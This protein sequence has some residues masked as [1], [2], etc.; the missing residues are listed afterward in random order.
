MKKNIVQDVIPP[1]KSI[2]NVTLP[3]RTAGLELQP[4]QDLTYKNTKLP[5]IKKET[6]KEDDFVR[7]VVIDD[8]PSKITET[9][10]YQY[11]YDQPKKSGK[12]ILYFSV[13]VFFLAAAFGLSAFF[14]SAEIRVSP[15]QETKTADEIFTAKK[16]VS[17][18]D[19]SYQ[20]VT[21]S[22]DVEK[23]VEA[24][25][26]EEVSKKAQGKIIIYNNYSS[27]SQKLV[28]TTRFETPEGMVFRLPNAVTVPGRALKDGKMVAGSIEVVVEA[29]KVGP[30]YNV[31]LKDFTIP[32]F[33]GDPR[34]NS[35]YA[36]SKTEMTGG[37]VGVQ[38][39]VSKELVQATDKDLE[40]SLKNSL[41]KDIIA[42]IPANYIL[43][44]N[45]ISY[46]LEPTI[47]EDSATENS[48]FKQNAI[49]RKKGTASAVIFDK[50]ALSRAILAK[51]SPEVTGEVV[52][53][54]NL[55]TLDFKYV[56]ETQEPSSD[57]LVTFSLKGNVNIIW[58]FDENKLKSDLL[59]LS[60]K[61]AKTVIGTYGTIKE[62][63]VETKPFWNQTIPEN[64][65]KVT[66][67]NTSS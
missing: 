10:T 61:E 44:P 67:T 63:W 31:G 54:N 21:I 20:V 47:Q 16:D 22:K 53:I 26:E 50:G 17:V 66:L 40:A 24:T 12:K 65:E 19:L 13:L 58:G 39:V 3:N 15:K 42:Q 7:P 52:K 4:G 25:G 57:S 1:K 34:F 41:S 11:D 38:K 18:S 60:K 37:F 36:R 55:E 30:N 33:K 59:G 9:P 51:I 43:Y 62:A 56:G 46:S 32:G 27:Q 23:T 8:K 5:K 45:S 35:I 28:A 64:P 6:V 48:F 2:R 14:K 49:L 29:D